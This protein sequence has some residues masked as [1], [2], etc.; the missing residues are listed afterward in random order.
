[1]DLETKEVTEVEIGVQSQIECL[2][3]EEKN[4]ELVEVKK[5]GGSMMS[6]KSQ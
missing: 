2:E 6:E 3:K 4:K 5:I 1:L